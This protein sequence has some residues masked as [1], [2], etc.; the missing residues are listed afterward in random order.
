MGINNHAFLDCGEEF[1][2]EQE[3]KI[4]SAGNVSAGLILV[5]QQLTPYIS[6]GPGVVHRKC[7]VQ[8]IKPP[9]SAFPISQLCGTLSECL[10]DHVST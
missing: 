7:P 8:Q 9:K 2:K 4:H 3:R 5:P 1:P 10:P 6:G